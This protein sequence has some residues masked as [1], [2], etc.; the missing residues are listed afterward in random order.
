VRLNRSRVRCCAICGSTNQLQEHHLGLHN[1]APFFTIPLCQQHHQAVTTAIARAGID[2]HYTNDTAERARRARLA[3]YVF[4]WFVDEQL[5]SK[6]G[7]Q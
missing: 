5:Q 7:D 1:H 6:T 4:L 2:P 3:A